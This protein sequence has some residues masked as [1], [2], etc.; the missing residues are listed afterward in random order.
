MRCKKYKIFISKYFDNELNEQQKDLLIKHLHLCQ[1]CKEEFDFFYKIYNNLLVKQ[2][3]LETST[4]FEIKLFEKLKQIHNQQT[5]RVS[6][7]FRYLV[8]ALGVIIIILFLFTKLPMSKKTS[9]TFYELYPQETIDLAMLD[10]YT[11]ITK[12]F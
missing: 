2:T 6:G 4:Y 7:Y 5:A 1:D 11:D 3:S 9:I 12:N 8:P 10:Y